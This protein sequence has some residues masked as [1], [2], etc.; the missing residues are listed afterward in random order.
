MPDTKISAFSDAGA[1]TGAEIVPLAGGG[2][3]ERTTTQAIADLGGGGGMTL[4]Q[5]LTGSGGPTLDFTTLGSTKTWRMLGRFI[6]PAS[7]E[8]VGL[9]FGTGGGPT[10]AAT[11]YDYESYQVNS[12]GTPAAVFG[13]GQTYILLGGAES[14]AG[15][16]V[17]F[18]LTIMQNPANTFVSVVGSATYFG[19]DGLFYSIRIGGGWTAVAALT[20]MRSFNAG[21]ANITSGVASLY[22]YS[23]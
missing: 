19:S 16:G 3:N 6:I 1:L 13:S 10:Y 7:D 11:N 18:D 20:A 2:A 8:T 4:L 22:G 17:S 9:R 14:S 12:A 15:R 5:T 23:E 21:G